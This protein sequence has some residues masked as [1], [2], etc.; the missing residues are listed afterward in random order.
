M[1]ASTDPILSSMMEMASGKS[2]SGLY[3]PVDSIESVRAEKDGVSYHC[4]RYEEQREARLTDKVVS[5]S[6][7]LDLVP[8]LW[9]P[10]NLS[11]NGIQS[12]VLDDH[13]GV[14]AC[15]LV[16]L[17]VD[18]AWWETSLEFGCVFR[19]DGREDLDMR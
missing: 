17:E 16:V 7:K 11:T 12:R 18:N 2:S 10:Q 5:N 1:Q 3:A 13:F 14:L 19:S 15:S 8:E 4:K 6:T 9:V